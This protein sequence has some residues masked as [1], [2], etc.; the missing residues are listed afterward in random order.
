VLDWHF[1][2]YAA[3]E[4]ERLAACLRSLSAALAGTNH[5]ISVILNGST[6]GSEAIALAAARTDPCIEVWR[7]AHADKS[8]AINQFHATIRK[9]AWLYGAADGNVVI[10]PRALQVMADRMARD[11]HALAVSGIAIN[12]R[13]MPKWTPE[14]ARGG[15][16]MGNLHALRPDFLDRMTARGIRL[17]TGLYRG[18]GLLGTMAAHNLDPLTTP[19]DNARIA[20]EELAQVEV[21]QLSPWRASHLRRAF[22]RKINQIRG[23]IEKA[24]IRAIIADRGFEALPD[25]ADDMIRTHLATHAPPPASGIDRY[26]QHLAITRSTAAIR[27][28]APALAA[29]RVGAD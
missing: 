24:A 8:N 7:I 19:W 2:V 14:R 10:R 28:Q 27:P 9:P 11:P 17:P 22:R 12:G 25:N 15:R 16:L 13:T 21:F 1:A 18:D 5:L 4:R 20:G 29:R 26:F 23:E 3:N 6:D